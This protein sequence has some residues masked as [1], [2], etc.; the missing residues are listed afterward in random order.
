MKKRF[1]AYVEA[2]IFISTMLV[3]CCLDKLNWCW[4][5]MAFII[6][7]GGAHARDKEKN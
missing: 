2:D 5:W 1:Y 4:F 7:L 3:M 6:L